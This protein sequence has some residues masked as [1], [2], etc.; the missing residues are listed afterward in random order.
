M[1]RP[2]GVTWVQQRSVDVEVSLGSPVGCPTVL[3]ACVRGAVSYH[4]GTLL[5]FALDSILLPPSR[6]AYPLFY[7][8]HGGELST[9]PVL[10][11]RDPHPV[12]VQRTTGSASAIA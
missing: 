2:S 10:L 11:R 5:H 6:S 4:R 9:A 1:R 3:S 8:A 7:I 12:I